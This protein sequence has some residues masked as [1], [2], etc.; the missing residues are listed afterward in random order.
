VLAVIDGE[1]IT[2]F[3]AHGT[4]IRAVTIVEGTRYYGNGK[5]KSRR[6]NREPSTMT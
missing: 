4:L 5:P 1:L 3:D 6:T 2:I